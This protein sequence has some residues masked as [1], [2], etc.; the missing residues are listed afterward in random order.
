MPAQS[1]SC[2]SDCLT[3]PD[4]RINDPI[5]SSVT[6][7]VYE[8]I[9]NTEKSIS[10]KLQNYIYLLTC[11]CCFVQYVGESVI[12]LH[13]R[14]NIHRKGKSGCEIL[15]NHFTKVCPNASFLFKF[16]KYSQGM[17]I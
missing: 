8:P 14:M 1:R 2:R 17:A 15:I 13:L 5:I 7:R 12:P 9:N 4:L 6:N 10:C 16:W 3:C 11:M